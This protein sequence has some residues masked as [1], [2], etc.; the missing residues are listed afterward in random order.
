[1]GLSL[2]GFGRSAS[3]IQNPPFQIDA[4]FGISA[5]I[6]EMLVFS[7]PG[8]IALLPAL[9]SAWRNGR[10]SGIRCRGGIT[11]DLEWD[12]EG[13][14]LAAELTADANQTVALEI[15]DTIRSELG[16]SFRAEGAQG[17]ANSGPL[18]VK[19]E[20]DTPVLVK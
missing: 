16:R 13:K 18:E 2:N 10:I 17:D 9:P 20:A 3:G 11:I 12:L 15:P 14:A 8:Y 1:M 6:L 19:L 5:A 7:K 4:N